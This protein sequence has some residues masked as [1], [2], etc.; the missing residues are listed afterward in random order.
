M[1]SGDEEGEIGVRPRRSRTA[2]TGKTRG[3]KIVEHV[4]GKGRYPTSADEIIAL[5][6]GPAAEEETSEPMRRSRAC[7][8]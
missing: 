4:R 1:P 2:G 6:H 3:E 5:M 8:S 7:R